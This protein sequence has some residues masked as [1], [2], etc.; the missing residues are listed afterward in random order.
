VGLLV[1]GLLA[2][3]QA[4]VVKRK[5]EFFLG[6]WHLIVS[7]KARLA[8][9]ECNDSLTES[10]SLYF[11]K[12]QK[13]SICGLYAKYP[14]GIFSVFFADDENIYMCWKNKIIC[15]DKVKKVSWR[16][17]FFGRRF[18][19]FDEKGNALL[20]FKYKTLWLGLLSPVLFVGDLFDDDWGLV[21]DLPSFVDSALNEGNLRCRLFEV[22]NQWGHPLASR[23]Q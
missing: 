1:V 11:I 21:A 17:V 10:I 3:H 13:K 15:L 4:V 12:D 6:Y 14:E 18:E 2:G 16:S 9:L 22:I 19:A 20:S 8:R 23:C 5:R 7:R